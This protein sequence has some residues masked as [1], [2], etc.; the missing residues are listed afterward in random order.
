MKL[1]YKTQHQ[2]P[3]RLMLSHPAVASVYIRRQCSRR[4]RRS[5][6][7]L[8]GEYG[9]RRHFP[10]SISAAI[11]YLTPFK[12]DFSLATSSPNSTSLE[13]A[14]ARFSLRSNIRAYYC[15]E[16]PGENNIQPR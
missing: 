12:E 15:L 10:A 3:L 9:V 1:E 13:L 4:S 5:A 14:L 7:G 16:Y 8:Y 6:L 2:A 11:A